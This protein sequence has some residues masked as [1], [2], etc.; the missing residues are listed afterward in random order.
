VAVSRA[1]IAAIVAGPEDRAGVKR[2]AVRSEAIDPAAQA[3]DGVL[4]TQL[5]V[6]VDCAGRKVRQGAATGHEQRNAAGL[7]HI[8]ARQES[9]WSAPAP[10]TQLESVWR[11]VCDGAFLPPL[12]SAAASAPPQAQPQPQPPPLAPTSR[13]APARSLSVQ[14][15]AFPNAVQAA[16]ARERLNRELRARLPTARTVVLTAE[17]HGATY[18][19]LLV[20]GFAS[21]AEQRDYCASVRALGRDCI[22]RGARPTGG[23]SAGAAPQSGLASAGPHR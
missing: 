14:V 22:I 5:D 9:E 11:A 13:P 16:A 3:M 15:G 6:Y 8:V 23:G 21:A 20:T 1:S 10:G 18:Y 7:G 17:V 19:R 4:S 12:T 2:V